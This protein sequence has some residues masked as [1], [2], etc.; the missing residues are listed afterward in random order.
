MSWFF[1]GNKTT[2]ALLEAGGRP[3]LDF[4]ISSVMSSYK[5]AIAT[6]YGT[7]SGNVSI[8]Y[9]A[10]ND[11]IAI[12]VMKGDQFAITWA[13]SPPSSEISGVN[14]TAEDAKGWLQYSA[15]K[16]SLLANGKE[17]VIVY[18]TLLNSDKSTINTSFGSSLDIPVIIN[19]F[20]QKLRF[21]FSSGKASRSM[22]F[23]S[24]GTFTIGASKLDGYRTYATLSLD[25]IA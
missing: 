12:R 13:G 21:R 11:A 4:S 14:F 22:T 1:A 15:S 17:T 7:T 10:D 25:L 8:Y 23:A 16:S 6:N 24:A 19:G 3:G 18:A 20:S 9:V 2:Q 5:S